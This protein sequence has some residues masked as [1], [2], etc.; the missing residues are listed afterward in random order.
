[1]PPIAPPP[2]TST[3]ASI[4]GRA[5][6]APYGLKRSAGVTAVLIASPLD[7]EFA[8]RIAREDERIEVLHDPAEVEL[9]CDDPRRYLAGE[10]LRNRVDLRLLY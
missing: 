8:T 1:M 7:E 5:S 3:L 2:T 9:F 10:E 4:M 6:P